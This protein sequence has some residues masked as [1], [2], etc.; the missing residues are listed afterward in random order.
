MGVKGGYDPNSRRVSRR[1]LLGVLGSGALGATVASTLHPVG[2]GTVHAGPAS[3][4]T[5]GRMFQLPAFAAP[6]SR[7]DTALRELGS[8]GGL[9]DA[10]DD[11]KKGPAALIA[12][13]SLNLTNRNNLDH[14]AG[15]TFMGQFMD[16]DMTFDTTSRLGS[17]TQPENTKNGRTPAFDLDSVYG[18]GPVATPQLYDPSDP[19]KLLVEGGG[20]F[21]DLP[22]LSN[23]QAIIGDPRNDENLII[24]GLQAAFLLFH[25][26]AVD[27]VRRE[28]RRASVD[29]FAE[30]RRMTTWHYHW[31]ILHEFLPLFVGQALVNDILSRGRHFYTARLGEAFIPVEFQGAA[32]RFGHSMVRPSYRANLE[33]D[34]GNPFFAM[35]FDSSQAGRADPDDLR[36][37][38]RA[39]RRFVGWQTFFDFDDG[40]VKPNKLIDTKISTPLFDLPLGAIA[41]GDPPT[42]LPQRNLLRQLTWQIPSGQSIALEIGEEPLRADELGELRDFGLGLEANTPLWYYVL[43]EAELR[44]AAARLGAVG[45]RIV[46][47]VIIGLLQTDPGSYLVAEPT[48]RPTLGRR[49]E[50][51]MVD[52]LKF[53][54]VDPDSRRQ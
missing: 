26:R 38:V 47:E 30:A 10:K 39:P 27:L 34:S 40:E 44:A 20:L 29:A 24:S 35:I 41:S 49:G 45:G 31:L 5:F 18:G 3:P 13:P 17:P 25:N 1:R 32:Y 33:G 42:S 23:N 21:E 51:R 14:P 8:P 12:D 11:L 52:F 19:A 54:R 36:G 4:G 50:F 16:H 46:G 37:G 9:M 6:S 15:A 22:R 43:K 7:L 28:S 53:A 2:V 48:W